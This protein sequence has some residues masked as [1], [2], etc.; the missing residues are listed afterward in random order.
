MC[1]CR[2]LIVP[3]SDLMSPLVETVTS[4]IIDRMMAAGP[5][6]STDIQR[7]CC[8]GNTR[9]NRP[10]TGTGLRVFLV[11]SDMGHV[12]IRKWPWPRNICW[13]LTSLR[14]NF[15]S[16]PTVFVSLR[17]IG[18]KSGRHI[19]HHMGHLI[20]MLLRNVRV[21]RGPQPLYNNTFACNAILP[22]TRI[23]G[24]FRLTLCT[25]WHNLVVQCRP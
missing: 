16:S 20:G 1:L 7:T 17:S 12:F 24:R 13:N 10:R 15:D 19:E 5:S 6:H 18:M 25:F 11:E 14:S 3:V 8:P 4:K 2:S 21:N 22:S 23:Y 9:I